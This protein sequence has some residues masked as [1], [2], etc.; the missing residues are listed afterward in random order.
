MGVGVTAVVGKLMFV[1]IDIAKQL[2]IIILHVTL[3]YRRGPGRVQ[4][5]F[6]PAIVWDGMYVYQAMRKCNTESATWLALAF[7]ADSWFK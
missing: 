4:R 5:L 3:L 1:E 6:S 2:L 7:N